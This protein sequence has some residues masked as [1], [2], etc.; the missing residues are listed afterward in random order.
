MLSIGSKV[1]EEHSIFEFKRIKEEQTEKISLLAIF[2]VIF[3]FAFRILLLEKVPLTGDEAYYWLWGKHLALGYHDDP[4]MVG[5]L[6]AVFTLFSNKILWIRLPSLISSTLAGLFLYLFAQDYFE[7]TK[8]AWLTLLFYLFM[9]ILAISS[10]ATFP[11]NPLFFCWTFTLW[12]AW[13]SLRDERYWILTGAGIGL[14]ILCK[15]TSFFLPVSLGLFFILNR[16]S[17]YWLTQKNFWKGVGAGFLVSLP[18]W[19]WNIQ[20][21]FENIFFQAHD[22]LGKTPLDPFHTFFN[23][24]ILESLS[25]SPF[26][27]VLFLIA[28]ISLVKKSLSGDSSS[29]F[30]LSFILPIQGFFLLSS[31]LTHAGIHWALPG[32]FPLMVAAAGMTQFKKLQKWGLACCLFFTVS[33][34]SAIAFPQTTAK[35]VLPFRAVFQGIGIKRFLRGKDYEELLGYKGFAEK[36]DQ[37]FQKEENLAPTFMLTDSY[38]LSSVLRYYTGNQA[39]TF[40]INGKGG[41]FARWDDFRKLKGENSL[42]FS[43]SPLSQNPLAEKALEKAFQRVGKQHE[44]VVHKEPVTRTFYYNHLMNLENPK[45]LERHPFVDLLKKRNLF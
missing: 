15:D 44:F 32:Y 22:H 38:D 30:L 42:W 9:P 18:F 13:K 19:I 12:A 43:L 25:V 3:V 20:H 40:L 39:L 21:K 2:G 23:Y 6:Q 36:A 8:K 16:K 7:D 1:R 45:P 31:F 37:L 5:W 26:L 34:S 35:L 4:P 24:V 41:Q 28:C 27:F 17:R 33:L 10:V 29:Q 14:A 11:D